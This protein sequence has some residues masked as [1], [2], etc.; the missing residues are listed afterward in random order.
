MLDRD[1]PTACIVAMPDE[2]CFGH[3]SATYTYQPH[4]VRQIEEIRETAN[5]FG[6]WLSHEFQIKCVEQIDQALWN[7]R[8][9]A[10]EDRCH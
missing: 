10:R 9:L 3:R 6:L 7:E 4:Q 8:P 1:L 5:S 2:L